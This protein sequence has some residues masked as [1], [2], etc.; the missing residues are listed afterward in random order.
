MNH[1]L[2]ILIIRLSSLGDILHTLPAFAGLRTS[3]PTAKID[4]LAGPKA[5]PLLTSVPGIDEIYILDTDRIRNSPYQW[6]AWRQLWDVIANLRA[7]QY[8]YLLDFQGLLKTAFIGFLSKSSLRLGFSRSLVREPP[9]H[10]FYHRTLSNPSRQLHVLELN[11]LLTEMIGARSGSPRFDLLASEKDVRYVDLLLEREK[12]MDFV[13]INPGGGWPTKRWM[14]ERYGAL[15]AKIRTELDLQVAV[16][17]G[18]GEDALYETIAAHSPQS[19]PHHIQVS[20]QQLIPLLKKARLF[21]GGDTGPFHLACALGTAVVGIM[22]PTSPI[23]NGPWTD[24][25]EV[26]TRR[27]PCSFCH[28]RTCPTNNECMDI[29]ADEVFAAV[30]RRLKSKEDPVNRKDSA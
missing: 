14:P 1:P 16:T 25:D 28:K 24:G 6:A 20:F 23:R 11:Q 3:F 15:A 4:W 30:V 22:G 29:A 5:R 26:V 2:K 18:P 13:I 10:W 7:R 19:T 17:T 12:L 27:L 9:A 21:I 8:D